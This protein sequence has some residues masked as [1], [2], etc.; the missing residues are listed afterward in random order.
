MFKLRANPSNKLD[1]YGPVL[2]AECQHSIFSQMSKYHGEETAGFVLS[3]DNM[4]TYR[5]TQLMQQNK[6]CC[7]YDM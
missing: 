4:F 5:G 7:S 1:Q 2:T 3:T 6:E